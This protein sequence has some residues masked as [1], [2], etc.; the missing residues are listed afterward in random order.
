MATTYTKSVS[1]TQD[2][3]NQKI[4]LVSTLCYAR[5]F[6]VAYQMV[7]DFRHDA[8]L[9]RPAIALSFF[10]HLISLENALLDVTHPD[11]DLAAMF[12]VF[13]QIGVLKTIAVRQPF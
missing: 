4:A 9:F 6:S 7:S 3:I 12:R 8:A 11:Y 1:L 2:A 13:E 5:R 10:N